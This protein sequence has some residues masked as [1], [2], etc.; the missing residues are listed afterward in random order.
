MSD[1]QE[2]RER[3]GPLVWTTVYR[4]L[5][6]LDEAQDCFQDVFVEVI[7]RSTPDTVQDWGAYLRWLATRRALNRLKKSRNAVKRLA[8]KRTGFKLGFDAAGS[9]AVRRR[10]GTSRGNPPGDRAPS[11][12]AGRSRLAVLCGTDELRRH[13]RP[14]ADLGQCCRGACPSRKTKAS[15]NARRPQRAREVRGGTHV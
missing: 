2:L 1:W 5:G 9:G 12:S 13:R 8:R 14:D 3:Y 7:E 10:K 15:R 6:N 11:E 4:V